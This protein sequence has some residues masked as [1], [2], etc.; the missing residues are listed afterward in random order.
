MIDK[1]VSMLLHGVTMSGAAWDDVVPLLTER[2]DVIAPTA[3]GHRGGPALVG[4]ATIAAVTDA[5]ERELDE[6]GLGAVHAQ[7]DRF[8]PRN[9]PTRLVVSLRR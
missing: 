9:W 6:R 7:T 5:A 8:A 1:P 2:F 4:K 3:A